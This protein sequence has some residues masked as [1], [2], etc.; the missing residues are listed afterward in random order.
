MGRQ[1]QPRV[2]LIDRA[3]TLFASA[4][5][6]RDEGSPQRA[7]RA[8]ARALDLF[9]QHG[10]PKCLDVANI[11][12]ERSGIYLDLGR[13]AAADASLEE[14]LGIVR[15]R[16]AG[17]DVARLHHQV[18]VQAGHVQVLRAKHTPARRLF[19]RALATAETHQLG[20]AALARARNGLGMVAKYTGRFAE[21]EA[22]YRRALRELGPPRDATAQLR[23]TLFH[24]L[25]GLEHARGRFERAEVWARRGLALRTHHC[26]ATST[27]TALDLAALAAIVQGGCRYEEAA[28]LY[29]RALSILRRRLGPDHVEVAFN[30]RQL[31]T[32]ERARRG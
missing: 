27:A 29:S 19:A 17:G 2:G 16:R 9:R 31:A 12:L 3:C 10:D 8:S 1:P 13:Y 30:L 28:R 24:N 23:A 21:G 5:R 4:Q 6:L 11:L 14:A 15:T 26:G 20:G 32:L 7:L 18:F 25:G 22:H